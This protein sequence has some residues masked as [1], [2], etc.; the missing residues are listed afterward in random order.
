MPRAG[1]EF[2][3][4]SDIPVVGAGVDS[5]NRIRVH[6]AALD[7]SILVTPG[8][9]GADA[10]GRLRVAPPATI[11]QLIFQYDNQPL[12]MQF[13]NVGTGSTIK[14]L[15]ESSLTLSTGGTAGGTSAIA[16]TKE[17][18]AYEP[19][20]SQLAMISGVLGLKKANVTSRI[21]YYDANNGIFFEM[22]SGTG[23]SVVVRSNTSGLIVENRIPQANWNVDRLDGTGVSTITLDLSKS[24]IFA[25]DFEWLGAG[26]V[27]FGFFI[28]DVFV[29]CH[30][31]AAAN[32][33]I[34]P[35]TNTGCLPC[36]AEIFNTGIT[37]TSTSMKMICL[38]VVSEGGQERPV[39]LNFGASN[40][41][42]SIT[43][44]TRRPVL[45]IRPKLLFGGQTNRGRIFPT[46]LSL[47]SQGNGSV[48]IEIVYNG[49]LTGASFSSVDPN[50]LVEKDT[51]ATSISGG[52]VYKTAY[53]GNLQMEKFMEI[54]CRYPFT[55]DI[56]GT[57]QDIISVVVTAVPTGD[58]PAI[59]AA[60]SWEEL[61]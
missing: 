51:S 56:G 1:N 16:Q 4:P 32:T 10:F 52:T 40:G 43:I 25:M 50:S 47:L 11:F 6:G 31:E 55:L 33:L 42:T 44:T 58:A 20:K 59:T 22:A 24:Q 27:R 26:R 39:L 23:A 61:R 12:F 8:S 34:S 15:N 38:S 13:A 7:G 60:I 57:I 36:R 3:Q 5:N 49:I 46:D 28:D 53:S 9:G 35:Y 54:L 17:Y 18:F 29:Y 45:S 41:A 21:G 37:A 19:G 2:D 14:T 30:S 48:L